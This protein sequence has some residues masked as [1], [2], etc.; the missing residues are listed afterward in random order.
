MMSRS[1]GRGPKR[2]PAKLRPEAA[3]IVRLLFSALVLT[4]KDVV[5]TVLD[6]DEQSLLQTCQLPKTEAMTLKWLPGLICLLLSF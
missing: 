5:A 6:C 3:C 4:S 1:S 2:C